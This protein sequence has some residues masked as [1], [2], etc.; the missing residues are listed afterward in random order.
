MRME[1]TK[2]QV[3]KLLIKGFFMKNNKKLF[4]SV[5]AATLLLSGVGAQGMDKK[6]VAATG[7]GAFAAG[8]AFVFGSVVKK[9]FEKEDL[10]AKNLNEVLGAFDYGLSV[11]DPEWEFTSDDDRLV[12]M[13]HTLKMVTRGSG[14]NN[15]GL[16]EQV[17]KTAQD[18]DSLKEDI[19]KIVGEIKK[20]RQY[21]VVQASLIDSIEQRSEGK[22]ILDL[23]K[24]KK[25]MESD[26][27]SGL[28]SIHEITQKILVTEGIAK[29]ALR[30]AND[31]LKLAK[32]NKENI[33]ED[34][35]KYAFIMKNVFG[36]EKLTRSKG[37]LAR[38]ISLLE[39]KFDGLQIDQ[40]ENNS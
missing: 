34:K 28:R 12:R 1:K 13:A 2:T 37:S 26:N 19:Q 3:H 15:P 14:T 11:Q 10:T 8:G 6:I 33:R 24:K 40:P 21:N 23:F 39:Q 31:S 27:G 36:E 35:K 9:M 20:Q 7:F 22:S 30:I 4:G 38:R 32:L 5:L 17:N 25:R 29:R 16:L 18:L